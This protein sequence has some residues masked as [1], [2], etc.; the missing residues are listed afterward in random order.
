MTSNVLIWL[1]KF[2]RRE[3]A[4]MNFGFEFADPVSR[5]SGAVRPCPPDSRTGLPTTMSGENNDN[6]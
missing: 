5:M 1:S 6:T 2:G 4:P 3:S